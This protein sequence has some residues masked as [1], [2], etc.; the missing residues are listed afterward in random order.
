MSFTWPFA[1]QGDALCLGQRIKRVRNEVCGRE[2]VGKDVRKTARRALDEVGLRVA[3]QSH[4]GI[5]MQEQQTAME[6]MRG[7][8]MP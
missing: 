4:D 2:G 3:K 5:S 1:L 6:E 7:E 8:G